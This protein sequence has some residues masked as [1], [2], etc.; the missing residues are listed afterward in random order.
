MS[1]RL[2]H[3]T[4]FAIASALTE[5]LDYKLAPA[6]QQAFHRLVYETCKAA[7][8][9]HD[10]TRDREAQRLQGAMRAL[11]SGSNGKP[12]NRKP[13]ERQDATIRD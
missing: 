1:G 5:K 8:A 2:T 11:D 13:R 3:D 7:I 10:T 6:E 4:A 9:Q 12:N